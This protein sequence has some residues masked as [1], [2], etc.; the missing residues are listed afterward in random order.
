MVVKVFVKD[1]DGL[2]VLEVV[3]SRK[4]FMGV[5]KTLVPLLGV[6]S[7]V[8]ILFDALPVLVF[9]ADDVTHTVETMVGFV[10]AVLPIDR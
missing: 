1:D 2:A 7:C 5:D 9:V 4:V 3:L 8:V 10:L 6:E